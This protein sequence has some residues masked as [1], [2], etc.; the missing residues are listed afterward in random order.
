MTNST[1]NVTNFNHVSNGQL[2]STSTMI[3]NNSNIYK[4]HQSNN[5]I[6]N[7][8]NF[9]AKTNHANNNKKN[10]LNN[11]NS[12]S[13]DFSLIG[14]MDNANN[15]NENNTS[16]RNMIN[17]KGN[18]FANGLNNTSPHAH[19]SSNLY[20]LDENFKISTKKN[21]YQRVNAS[22]ESINKPIVSNSKDD[23]IKTNGNVKNN[24]LNHHNSFRLPQV[25]PFECKRLKLLLRLLYFYNGFALFLRKGG[26]LYLLFH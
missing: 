23:S 21:S 24:V 13:I 4:I 14:S 7:P 20:F 1:N 6:N 10:N 15:P 2:N 3:L 19:N 17:L 11:A 25:K 8:F 26:H 22:N 9:Y 18:S 16:S 12:N 5:S